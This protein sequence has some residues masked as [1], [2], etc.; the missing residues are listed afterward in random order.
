MSAD[1]PEFTIRLS[2]ENPMDAG[3]L[4]SMLQGLDGLFKEVARAEG[5]D[6]DS[7]GLKVGR[8]RLVCDGC[9]R[10]HTAESTGWVKDK[11]LDY[12]P[13]CQTQPAVREAA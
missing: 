10:E 6:P 12:C 7:I 3:A 5:I 4:G 13:A 11:G 1:G 8:I 2:G 9:E